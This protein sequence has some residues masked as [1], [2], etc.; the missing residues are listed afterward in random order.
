MS[1]IT[2]APQ[3]TP[4]TPAPTTPPT[5]TPAGTPSTPAPASTP[6]VT[7]LAG[8]YEN[9]EALNSGIRELDPTVTPEVLAAMPD[10][11]AEV[12][13]RT[14]Q[15]AFTKERQQASGQT[16][17]ANP[18]A[19]LTAPAKVE[20]EAGADPRQIFE[21]AGVN[22]DAAMQAGKLSEADKKALTDKY[23]WD[24]TT[25]ALA[26]TAGRTKY[27]MTK[28][29]RD[30][31]IAVRNAQI[32]SQVYPVFGGK[33]EMD[34]LLSQAQE[35]LGAAE[36]DLFRK[37]LGDPDVN[38]VKV[39]A[40]LFKTRMAL[41]LGQPTGTG[42]TATPMGTV[43]PKP[44]TLAEKQQALRNFSK[45][46]ISQAELAAALKDVPAPKKG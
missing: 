40:E 13:Y 43:A 38:A 7:K 15:R 24:K 9:R 12:L 2:P 5:G 26:E 37:M 14:A 6:P 23:G 32:E 34:K 31:A 35:A 4:G 25:I 11:H 42:V 20:V 8:K 19:A 16:G 29:E 1:V 44:L 10:A 17:N 27:E 21:A 18:F 3:G 41:K 36:V 39:A 45:G 33:Q 22:F 46:L 28:A 30:A